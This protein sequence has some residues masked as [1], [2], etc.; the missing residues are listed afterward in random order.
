[1]RWIPLS[2]NAHRLDDRSY[3]EHPQV[4][5][6]RLQQN[7]LRSSADAVTLMPKRPIVRTGPLMVARP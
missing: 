6:S 4:A 3:A 7:G 1:M 2:K 5:A